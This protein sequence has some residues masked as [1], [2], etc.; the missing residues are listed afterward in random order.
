MER[1]P[2]ALAQP[3]ANW[4][5]LPLSAW[6]DT[7]ATLHMWMQ[8]VGKICL[9]LTPLVESLLEH[10]VPR[11]VARP[12]H[13]A[14]GDRRRRG[15]DDDVRLRRATSSSSSARTAA[16][17]RMRAEAADRSRTSIAPSWTTLAA[18]GVD[19]RIWPMPVEIPDPIRF[20]QDTVHRSYDPAA[21]NDFWRVLVAIKPVFERF[22]AGFVGKCSPVHFFWGSF[23]LAVTRFSGRRAPERPGADAIT[24]EAYSHEV[25]S[26]GFWP[27]SGPV[28]EPAFYA[29]A[30]PEP[31][32]LQDG[33]RRARGGV[34][35][36]RSC[37]SSSCRTTR[38]ARRR[39]RPTTCWRSSEAPTIA[40]ADPRRLESIGSRAE[41]AGV[42]RR[43]GGCRR[44]DGEDSV[45]T[46]NET[47]KNKR[48]R[49]QEGFVAFV[50]FVLR[51]SGLH[52]T[53]KAR[54]PGR[55]TSRMMAPWRRA[56][57]PGS[58]T[59]PA[60]AGCVPPAASRFATAG[61]AGVRRT[62]RCR[63]A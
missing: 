27:G 15:D 39:H 10:H 34:L 55:D 28:Q 47:T 51:T 54:L 26:H 11:H 62:K 22:R 3:G 30:A 38:C 4:P 56:T 44:P 13:A 37:P 1:S 6:R 14:D 32:G 36:R 21:A 46:T 59:P 19:V 9:A 40:A 8:V 18:L 25:I 29:Y 49:R 53:T 17:E 2:T 5:A 35:L 45:M 23:D 12:D 50:P 24:R 52:L 31:D 61:A 43:G 48:T 33:G 58:S 16:C 60:P 42:I 7:Y 20:E 63:S 41:G 57:I